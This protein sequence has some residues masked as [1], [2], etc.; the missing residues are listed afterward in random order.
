MNFKY[1]RSGNRS[2]YLVGLIVSAGFLFAISVI[3]TL[4]GQNQL[5]DERKPLVP[6]LLQENDP[7]GLTAEAFKFVSAVHPIHVDGP[8][9]FIRN[10]ETG[11]V[12]VVNLTSGD[13]RHVSPQ[14]EFGDIVLDDKYVPISHI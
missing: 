5:S 1:R 2:L 10:N 7:T 4:S 9:V 11:E 8:R 6:I 12:T 13:V 14:S 3:Q